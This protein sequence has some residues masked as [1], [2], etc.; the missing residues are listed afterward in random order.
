ML[1]SRED[2]WTFSAEIRSFMCYLRCAI[3]SA[4][5]QSHRGFGLAGMS[6]NFNILVALRV[7]CWRIEKV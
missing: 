5:S 7:L 1:G 2:I 3:I 4:D 6:F